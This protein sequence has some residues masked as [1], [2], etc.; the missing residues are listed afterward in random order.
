[1]VVENAPFR[2]Q[3]TDQKGMYEIRATPWGY[4]NDLP[5]NIL[6]LLDCLNE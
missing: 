1:M 3:V 6:Q 2:F 5:T 4:I